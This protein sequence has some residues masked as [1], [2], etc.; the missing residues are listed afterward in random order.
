MSEGSLEQND[1]VNLIRTDLDY[2]KNLKE[3]CERNQRAISDREF[4]F[5]EEETAADVKMEFIKKQLGM[6]DNVVI[7]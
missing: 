7:I 5:E 6:H 1:A 3:T 4:E 2:W